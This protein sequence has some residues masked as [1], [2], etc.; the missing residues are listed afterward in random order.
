[1]RILSTLFIVSCV[2]PSTTFA[3]KDTIDR[4]AMPYIESDTV[5]GMSVGIVH[6][7]RTI[8]RGY[9]RVSTKNPRKPD[10]KTIYEIGSISKVFTGILLADAM[11]QGQVSM[12]TPVEALLPNGTK[13]PH[14]ENTM[15][16]RLWHLSTH[17]SGLPRMPDNLQPADPNNPYADYG[18]ERMIQF[19]S[20]FQPSKRPGE[21]MEY[22]NLAA[23]LLGHVLAKQQETDYQSL[24]KTRITAQLGMKDTVT[25]LSEDQ[26]KRFASPYSEGGTPNHTWD[27]DAMV[28]AGGIRSSVVDMLKFA[29]AQLES[30]TGDLGTAID[31][32][33][34]IHQEPIDSNDFAMGLGWHVAR[35]GQ[36]RWHNGQTGGYHSVIYVNRKLNAAVVILCNTATFEIDA[37]AEQL[38]RVAA[39]SQ[40]SPREFPKTEK[41]SPEKMNRY[42]GKYQLA[43]GAVFTV[44]VKDEKLL[45][46]LTGQ[47]TFRVYPK[48]ETVWYY[49]VVP[50]ELTFKVDDQGKCQSVELFQNGLRQTAKRIE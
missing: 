29:K 13:M 5:V 22:S 17:T 47:S 32:A 50:A 28:G 19:L 27:F 25:T 2:L 12:V 9:G 42:V 18:E 8:V 7:D 30:P 31:M 3:Q 16:I 39:G 45:V 26:K 43:P 34:M 48:S 10:G 40:E 11:T 41:V 21:H 49:K 44:S 37:L 14:R 33:W 38:M 20:K 1:M 4:L 36:T 46:G 6:G 24:L 35:D 15:P 23:G